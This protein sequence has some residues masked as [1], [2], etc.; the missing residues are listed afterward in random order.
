M[1]DRDRPTGMEVGDGAQVTNFGYPRETE[2]VN[3]GVSIGSPGVEAI[4][5]G[6]EEP[7]DQ[8][9]TQDAETRY[10][11]GEGAPIVG[12]LRSRVARQSRCQY[13]L[14]SKPSWEHPDHVHLVTASSISMLLELDGL[15]E[16]GAGRGREDCGS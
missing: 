12:S 14:I 8:L 11:K 15:H 1:S 9:P 6:M 10:L 13:A 5:G 4:D 2:C 3:Q 16:N 7:V